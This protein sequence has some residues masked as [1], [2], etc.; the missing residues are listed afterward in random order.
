MKLQS[1]GR[2]KDLL[3]KDLNFAEYAVARLKS[4]MA[5]FEKSY[6]MKWKNF[7]RK[8]EEGKKINWK[9]GVI[10]SLTMIKYKF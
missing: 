9:D 3:Q 7:L 8:F 10:A 4:E 6:D 2:V 5:S 1:T